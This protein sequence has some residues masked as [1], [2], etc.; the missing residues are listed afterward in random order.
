ME[1]HEYYRIILGFLGIDLDSFNINLADHIG[2]DLYQAFMSKPE[3][4]EYED[5]KREF[6]FR[7]NNE[8]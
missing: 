7:I 5:M 1:Q 6:G 2:Y 3:R 8:L 4:R